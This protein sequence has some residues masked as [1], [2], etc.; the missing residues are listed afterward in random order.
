VKGSWGLLSAVFMCLCC[1]PCAAWQGAPA[2]QK[3]SRGAYQAIADAQRELD[4][5]LEPY[6]AMN[7]TSAPKYHGGRLEIV[8]QPRFFLLP[9]SLQ[10]ALLRDYVTKGVLSICCK[11]DAKTTIVVGT[12]SKHGEAGLRLNSAKVA[13]ITKLLNDRD[14]TEFAARAAKFGE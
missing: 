4:R 1:N 13:Q 14:S 3:G 6:R 11:T 12:F 9:K 8:A 5:Q 7:L 2:L 10:E